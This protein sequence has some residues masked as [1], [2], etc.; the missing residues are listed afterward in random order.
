MTT[1]YWQPDELAG[2]DCS[3]S[4]TYAGGISYERCLNEFVFDSDDFAGIWK[5]SGV[6]GYDKV[7]NQNWIVTDELEAALASKRRSRLLVEATT[8]RLPRL[9]I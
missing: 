6:A 5:I 4:D 3:D 7:G 2:D 8:L 9:L 1:I